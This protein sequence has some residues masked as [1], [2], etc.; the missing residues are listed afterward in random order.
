[1]PTAMQ[2]FIGILQ[3]AREV[4]T[5]IVVIRGPD[6]AG[7]I[8]TFQSSVLANEEECRLLQWDPMRGLCAV[9]QSGVELAPKPGTNL[10]PADM[11][12]AAQ[13]LPDDT[14]LFFSNAHRFLDDTNVLQGIY[15]LR[16]PFKSSHRM[17]VLLMPRGTEV[18]LE[19]ADHVLILD[20][21]LPTEE[22]FQEIALKMVEAAQGSSTDF[23]SPNE[24]ELRKVVDALIGLPRF[25]GEEA[26][27][28][29]LTPT[30]I[31]L[32]RLWERKVQAIETIPGLSVWKGNE[33][34]SDIGGVENAKNFLRAVLSG[35]RRYRVIVFIDEV[36][37]AFAG[38][39]TDTS[40]VMTQM[41]GTVLTWTQD[42]NA[43]GCI[44]V[45]PTGTAKS[46]L[47]KAAGNEAGLPTITFDLSRMQSAHV[48]ESGARLRAALDVI[49]AVSQGN[50]LFIVTSNQLDVLPP[51]LLRRFS[52]VTMFFDIPTQP[53]K[54]IIWEIYKKQ[55]RLSGPCPDDQDWTGADIRN[56]CHNAHLMRI[57]LKETLNYFAPIGVSRKEQIKALRVACSGQFVSAAKP[58]VYIY[59]DGTHSE[60]SPKAERKIRFA[61]KTVSA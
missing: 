51:E 17:L 26:L 30:G 52:L 6:A 9:N 23:A 39:G 16:D 24:A 34:F 5:P 13:K 19:L 2:K 44:F 37:K 7:T 32:P 57:P 27:A 43:D 11:L 1:M 61:G 59:D 15:N 18:P 22:D 49:E 50:A 55:Y 3:A 10:H 47:A 21:P 28:L 46:A 31:D 20:E 41:T 56:C 33:K 40:G 45:G 36:E 12:T 42:H 4:S 29:S 14:V 38:T 60:T 35:S 54:E 8:K 58:G 25:P 53:E 48:G